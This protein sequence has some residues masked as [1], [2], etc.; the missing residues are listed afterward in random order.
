MN[1]VV[2]ELSVSL[3]LDG[4]EDHIGQDELDLIERHLGDLLGSMLRAADDSKE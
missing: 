3:E 2:S 1:E 4:P